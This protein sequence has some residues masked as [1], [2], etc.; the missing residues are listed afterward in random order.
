MLS[1]RLP[2]T[3][4]DTI[5]SMAANIVKV[6]DGESIAAFC[7]LMGAEATCSH[8]FQITR[9]PVICKRLLGRTGLEPRP[10][11]VCSYS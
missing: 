4:D 6:V 1:H 2:L 8:E 10:S 11:M 7:Q 3:T 9:N 5:K